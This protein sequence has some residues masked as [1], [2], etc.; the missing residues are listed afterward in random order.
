MNKK[1]QKKRQQRINATNRMAAKKAIVSNKKENYHSSKSAVQL[2]SMTDEGHIE[3]AD[4][5]AMTNTHK[6]FNFAG[7]VFRSL[8]AAVEQSNQS[9]AQMA[10]A[11]LFKTYKRRKVGDEFET[12][13]GNFIIT[14]DDLN[15]IN[16][17]A[18]NT[19]DVMFDNCKD[20]KT[21]INRIADAIVM[22]DQHSLVP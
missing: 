17:I 10:T 4:S 3:A 13:D 20:K 15:V 22:V 9:F 21:L 2:F 16:N 1:Q 11:S 5:I 8:L 18:S 7:D 19:I 14:E 6:I 12:M